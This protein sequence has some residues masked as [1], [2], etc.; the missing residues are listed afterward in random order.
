MERISSFLSNKVLF[1]TGATGFLGKAVIVQVLRHVSDVKC[2]YIPVRERKLK[3]GGVQSAEKRLSQVF[4][5]SAFDVLRREWGEAF[6][7]R[8]HDKVRAIVWKGLEYDD[9][10]IDPVE[11]SQLQSEVDIVISSAATV[12]FDEPVDMALWQN[13]IGLGRV[14]EFAKGCKDASFVYVSTAYV[15]GQMTGRIPEA[16]TP[17][18]TSIAQL[19]SEKAAPPYD[20]DEQISEIESFSSRVHEEAET[21]ARRAEFERQLSRQN[22]GKRVTPHRLDHQLDALRKRWIQSRLVREGLR[23]GRHHGWNDAYTM[24]KAMGE[25]LIQRERGSMPVAIVRPSI[26]ESSLQDPEPGWLEGLKVADP[27]IAHF[28]KGRL[29]DFPADPRVV[30]DVVPVDIVA[31]AIL[32]VL[33]RIRENDEIEVYHVGTGARNPIR[34]GEI[35]EHVYDYY[36]TNP[37]S[38]R[39]GN[40]IHVSRWRF[41]TAERFAKWCRVRYQI[42]MAVTRWIL[43]R[44]PE[45]KRTNRMVRKISLGE[46]TLDRVLALS[47]IYAPYTFL[48]C[49][50]ETGNLARLHEEMHPEDQDRFNTDV[51]RIDWR[52]YVQDIH[53]PGLHRHVLKSELASSSG[54]SV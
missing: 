16:L 9:L 50:F 52:T 28:G 54:S 24:T 51:T 30:L 35:F 40:P 18:D 21:P 27:L 44:L 4:G 10:G 14:L 17:P 23:R 2:I 25:Q 29:S 5:S 42:P 20:L 6:E 13:T 36:R 8:C 39:Q 32:S 41:P 3:S 47:E 31:N 38:D 33:P 37:V 7:A 46:A 26:I 19:L 22:R 12:V 1:V 15:N 48:N 11:R 53:I 34:F 43:D 49:R 45:S